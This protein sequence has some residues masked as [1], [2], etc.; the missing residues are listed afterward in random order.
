MHGDSNRRCDGQ[1]KGGPSLDDVP[2]QLAHTHPDT[3]KEMTPAERA[4]HDALTEEIR[5]IYHAEPDP[6]GRSKS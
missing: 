6:P 1:S 3:V 4:E 2:Y 5:S